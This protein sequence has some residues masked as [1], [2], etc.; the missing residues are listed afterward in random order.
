MHTQPVSETAGTS[1]DW[2]PTKAD[3]PAFVC[4][5]CG[6]DNVWYRVWESACGGYEDYK[7]EC[8]GCGRVWWVESDDG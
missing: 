8:R 5:I 1:G 3:N 2:K 6:S 4:R 7:Y